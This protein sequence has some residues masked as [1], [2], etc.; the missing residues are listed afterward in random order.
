MYIH[1][2]FFFFLMHVYTYYLFHLRAITFLAN[3]R[4]KNTYHNP[5]PKSCQLPL[6]CS[7][8]QGIRGRVNINDS[9]PT[10]IFQSFS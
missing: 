3:K 8:V 5:N 7:Q 10:I 1:I 2:V 6:L 9:L 4:G